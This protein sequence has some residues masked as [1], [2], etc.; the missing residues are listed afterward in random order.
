M[1]LIA[2]GP[3]GFQS[4]IELGSGDELFFWYTKEIAR[5][6]EVAPKKDDILILGGGT[7]TMPE[8]F[9]SKYPQS[10]VDVVEIDP[11]LQAVAEKYFFYNAPR[12]VRDINDDARTYINNTER[13]YD[14][15][16]VDIYN[17]SEIPFT[18][19]T[20]EYSAAMRRIVNPGGV[21][22]VNII[23]NDKGSCRDF[24]E[25]STSPYAQKFKFGV[26]KKRF[27]TEKK[28]NTI[29]V[30]SDNS[31][32]LGADYRQVDT[33]KEVIYSDDFSPAEALQRKCS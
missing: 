1:R 16:V 20:R 32:L 4:G 10:K 26:F 2:T 27:D 24:W 8:Y 33:S 13:R 18:L 31:L 21:V 28:T 9:A 30:F 15:V 22:V 14:V 11:E 6:V 7:Y 29:E 17:D 25:A 23:A 12:N 19:L 5:V 3:G